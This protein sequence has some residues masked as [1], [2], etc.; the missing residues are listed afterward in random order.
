M[1][2]A[3][4]LCHE[5]LCIQTTLFTPCPLYTPT[6][7]CPNLRASKLIVEPQCRKHTLLYKLEKVKLRIAEI[8]DEELD[9]ALDRLSEAEKEGDSKKVK[10]CEEE[11]NNLMVELDQL[12]E[13]ERGMRR[14]VKS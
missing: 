11:W 12:T 3:L 13:L 1:C 4:L 5:C 6:T 14:L 2:R 10:L 9:L 8:Q 7:L